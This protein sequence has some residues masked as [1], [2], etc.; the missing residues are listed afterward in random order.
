LNHTLFEKCK[1]K[2][3]GKT[4]ASLKS[5]SGNI[6]EVLGEVKN[7]HLDIEDKKIVT[8]TIITK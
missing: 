6:I 4:D 8:N 3:M 7:L 5:V 1:I 2:G